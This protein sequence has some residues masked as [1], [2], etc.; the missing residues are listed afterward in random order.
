MK[1]K[2]LL[3]AYNR[4]LKLLAIHGLADWQVSVNGSRSSLAWAEHT[5]KEIS[6]SKFFIYLS[7]RD[8]FDGVILHEIAHALL[9]PGFGHGK[10]F[11]DLCKKISPNSDYAVSG[12]DI[13]IRRYFFKCPRCGYSGYHNS[14]RDKACASCYAATGK[15]I[16]FERTVNTVELKE[17]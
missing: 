5:D 7:T 12:M 14:K 6:I 2:K 16:P 3:K 10:E 8:E 11:T 9:G 17:W 1:E 4:A 13:G 15:E